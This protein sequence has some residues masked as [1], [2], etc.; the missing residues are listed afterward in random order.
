MTKNVSIA[1]QKILVELTSH[2][3]RRITERNIKPELLSLDN[4]I[5]HNIL[6]SKHKKH[7]I[8]NLLHNISIVIKKDSPVRLAFITVFSG[9]E[10][11]SDN[12]NIITF[13]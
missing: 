5:I 13:N 8:K 1:G 12:A 11:N 4:N 6:N 10:C 7:I 3:L 2:F 9:L